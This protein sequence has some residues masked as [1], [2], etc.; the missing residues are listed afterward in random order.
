M[1]RRVNL[2]HLIACTPAIIA[3]IFDTVVNPTPTPQLTIVIYIDF[4]CKSSYVCNSLYW[5]EAFHDYHLFIYIQMF[6]HGEILCSILTT[7]FNV[8]KQCQYMYHYIL[9]CFVL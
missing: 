2:M 8:S 4:I 5:Q 6:F 3:A 1:W 9:H 7:I